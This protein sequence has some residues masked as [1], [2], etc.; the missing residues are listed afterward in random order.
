MQMRLQINVVPDEDPDPEQ[1]N[2]VQLKKTKYTIHSIRHNSSYT[3]YRIPQATK[4]QCKNVTERVNFEQIG[5]PK[6]QNTNLHYLQ[7]HQNRDQAKRR[8]YE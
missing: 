2:R 6:T 5:S 4:S 8:N 7:F 3:Y 1:M